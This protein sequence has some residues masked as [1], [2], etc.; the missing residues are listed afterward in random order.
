MHL[1]LLFHSYT[2]C[3][4]LF[5]FVPITHVV[6]ISLYFSTIYTSR[7]SYYHSFL[8]HTLQLLVATIFQKVNKIM[9][10]P[11]HIARLLTK[12]VAE[13]PP[14]T[15]QLSHYSVRDEDV[16]KQLYENI[17]TI[18]NS[19][20]YRL[21]NEHTLDLVY[22]LRSPHYSN[23]SDEDE[24]AEEDIGYDENDD[25]GDNLLHD[26]SLEYRRWSPITM[27]KIQIQAKGNIAGEVFVIP[28]RTF[29]TRHAPNPNSL[30]VSVWVWVLSLGFGLGLGI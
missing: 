2:L 22:D 23:N 13:L 10:N 26:F 16:A 21:E 9:T 6:M 17:I 15:V 25:A 4:S 1:S 30:G 20:E 27:K 7:C 8:F 14:S 24:V 18:S 29:Q 11:H 3:I 28:S 12:Y 19:S 5:S